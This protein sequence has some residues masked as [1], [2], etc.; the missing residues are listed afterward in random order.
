M[1][2][3]KHD[4]NLLDGILRMKDSSEMGCDPCGEI[5]PCAST[6][7]VEVYDDAGWVSDSID[8]VSGDH[9]V[10]EAWWRI[11]GRREVMLILT[12]EGGLCP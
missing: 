8:E 6:L 3:Y 10:H 4:T 9:F 5:Y 11:S 12:P 2:A 7:I 1:V